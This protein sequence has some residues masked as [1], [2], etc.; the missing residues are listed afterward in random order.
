MLNENEEPQAMLC[1]SF[2]GISDSDLRYIIWIYKCKSYCCARMY[3]VK[4]KLTSVLFMIVC[5]ALHSGNEYS[6]Q[7]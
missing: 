6:K 5:T 1:L 3:K 2:F 7:C 4:G